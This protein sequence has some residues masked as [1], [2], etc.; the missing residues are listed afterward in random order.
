M[1]FMSNILAY[2]L[3][4][5]ICAL[6]IFIC[7]FLFVGP[8]MFI[9]ALSRKITPVLFFFSYIAYITSLFPKS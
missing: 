6:Q 7:S 1:I 5:C 4:T 8:Y 3:K 9:N 2:I